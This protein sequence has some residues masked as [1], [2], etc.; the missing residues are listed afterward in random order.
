MTFALRGAAISFSVF[1]IVYVAM[2]VLVCLSWRKAHLFARRLSACRAANFLFAIRMLPLGSALVATILF[3]IPSFLLFEPR[4]IVE[5]VGSLTISLAL[6]GVALIVVGCAN[7]CL[8]LLRASRSVALWT[9]DAKH[10]GSAA[11]VSLLSGSGVIPAMT[12]VGIFRSTI[13]LSDAARSVLSED[14]M[15]TTLN[16]ELAHIQRYDNLKKLLL[17]LVTFPNMGAVEAAWL[18]TCEIAADES[19]VGTEAEALAL[20]SALLK[21]SRFSPLSPRVDLTAALVRRPAVMIQVRVQ[22]LMQWTDTPT[23][24]V[25]SVS[26]WS[27]LSAGLVTVSAVAI[28]Y[29]PLLLK[30]HAITEWMVR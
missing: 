17:C 29:S 14:E 25:V 23:V 16:H 10:V 15:R 26:R 21:L 8:A 6:L 12:A 7:A 20:A 24:P 13:L 11:N 9:R 3:A 18:E 1:A 30:I 4:S 28:C 5:P 2:S 22:K 27:I 19:A